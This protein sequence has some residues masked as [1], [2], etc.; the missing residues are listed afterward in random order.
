M[1]I[2]GG[3]VDVTAYHIGAEPECAINIVHP[4]TGD[5]FGGTKV[6]HEFRRFLGDLVDDEDF[7]HY[8]ENPD[9]ILKAKHH[10]LLNEILKDTFEKQKRIFGEKGGIGGKVSVR[11]PHS[12]FKEYSGILQR[13]LKPR[14]DYGGTPERSQEQKAEVQLVDQTLRISYSQM[15]KFFEP[16]ITGIRE[17]VSG[18]IDQV[19][20]I[21]TIYMVGGFGGC[22]YLSNILQKE[23]GP[24]YNFI[25]PMAPELAVISG[26]VLSRQK[27]THVHSRRAAATYGVRVYIPFDDEK[28]AE[29]YKIGDEKTGQVV[30]DN[31]FCTIV[32]VGDMIRT[33]EVF[34]STHYAARHDQRVMHIDIHSSLEKDVWYTTGL[35][36][37][38]SNVEKRA[39]VHKVSELIVPLPKVEVAPQGSDTTEGDGN[40]REVELFFDFGHAEVQVKGYDCASKTEVNGIVDF[41]SVAH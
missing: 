3:T 18:V 8:L 7:S 37:S 35:R 40:K 36:P 17:C 22:R 19:K 29:R 2:G 20:E 11:L 26:A 14:R 32:E 16:V 5:A 15:E 34:T 24:T 41:L 6:N 10:A 25:I 21:D 31:V 38:N 28:H 13:K 1:D 33:D 27:P 9:D 4:P 23:L 30:C 12:F 39:D